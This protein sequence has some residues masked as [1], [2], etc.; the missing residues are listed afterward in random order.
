MKVAIL[1]AGPSGMMAAHAV[2]QYGHEIVIFDKNPDQSRR[3]SGVYFLHENC[4]LLLDPVTI[5]QTLL[6]GHGMTDEEVSHAYGMKVYGQD[7][8]KTSVLE[9]RKTR[10]VKGYNA[11]KAI[12]V[13]WHLYGN[14]INRQEIGSFPGVAAMKTN[15]D[16][17]ISTIPAWVLFPDLSFDSVETW[18]E[19]GT[20]PLDEHFLYYN[21]NPYIPWYR[22]SAMFGVFTREFGWDQV[23]KKREGY[24]YHLVKKVIGIRRGELPKDKRIWFT[25]RFGAWD[26]SI[27]THT[28]YYDILGRLKNG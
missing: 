23:L 1:G 28:V 19:V 27:L 26:K 2:A 18:I 3:N 15:Y 4:H 11:G 25:G 21:V 8:A 22:C 20:A 16:V 12:D 10:K 5:E 6:G 13:L 17:I 14:F 7:I 24:Q 9:A